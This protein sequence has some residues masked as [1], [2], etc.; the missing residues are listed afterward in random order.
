M[1]QWQFQSGSHATSNLH[2]YS[3]YFSQVHWPPTQS[4]RSRRNHLRNP[5]HCLPWAA[6]TKKTRMSAQANWSH[7]KK[8][9]GAFVQVYTTIWS[10]AHVKTSTGLHSR[11]NSIITVHTKIPEHLTGCQGRSSMRAR[12]RWMR[13]AAARGAGTPDATSKERWTLFLCAPMQISQ[14]KLQAVYP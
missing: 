2:F 12:C 6:D 4:R 3:P 9:R 1:I 5:L 8:T 14:S 11:N 10:T 13:A 7:A